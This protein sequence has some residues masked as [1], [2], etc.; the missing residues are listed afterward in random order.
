MKGPLFPGRSCYPISP[1]NHNNSGTA[2]NP[3][4]QLNTILKILGN[5]NKDDMEFLMN[6][7]AKEYVKSVYTCHAIELKKLYPDV[8]GKYLRF[9]KSMLEFDPR[10]R[11][12]TETLLKDEI[13]SQFNQNEQNIRME[14][15]EDDCLIDFETEEFYLCKRDLNLLFMREI[16]RYRKLNDSNI[17]TYWEV[18]LE[19]INKK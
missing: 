9:L 17:K 2:I 18:L 13:F 11:P 10:K 4:D 6:E 7:S 5:P 3:E 15:N 8:H 16:S 1:C 14:Q 12:N 19:A